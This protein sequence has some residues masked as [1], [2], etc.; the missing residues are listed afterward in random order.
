MPRSRKWL[1]TINNPIEHS[2]DHARSRPLPLTCPPF[3]IGVCVMNKAMNAKHFIPMY[4]LSLK[5]SLHI[6]K[7][8]RVSPLS[9]VTLPVT[10]PLKI[11]PMSS[12]TA[13]SS[14]SC[15]TAL[16]L[17]RTLAAISTKVLTS[18]IPLRRAEKCPWSSKASLGM[19]IKLL[20]L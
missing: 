8:T 5:T 11:G 9:T 6:H 10:S 14:T 15:R 2:F 7:L 13:Q 12:R 3:S 16:T 19:P 4:I 20:S 1:I 17:R 18:P